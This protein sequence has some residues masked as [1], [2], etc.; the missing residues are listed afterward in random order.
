MHKR[1]VA[2]PDAE[3]FTKGQRLGSVGPQGETERQG[4]ITVPIL[5]LPSCFGELQRYLAKHN[6]FLQFGHRQI[7]DL[8][9]NSNS[10]EHRGR[11]R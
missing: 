8:P 4:R 6:K 9:F 7:Q 11:E 3:A 2:T 1:I 10:W 5:V